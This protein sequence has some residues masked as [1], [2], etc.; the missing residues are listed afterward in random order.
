MAVGES[1]KTHLNSFI[2]FITITWPLL[3]RQPTTTS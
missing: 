2:L 3:G 1:N